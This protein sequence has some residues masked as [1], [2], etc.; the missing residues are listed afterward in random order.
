VLLPPPG[1]VAWAQGIAGGPGALILPGPIYPLLCLTFRQ[2]CGPLWGGWQ[3]SDLSSNPRS[4]HSYLSPKVWLTRGHSCTAP[5]DRGF[6]EQRPDLWSLS[7]GQVS[8]GPQERLL[9][10][11]RVLRT[12]TTHPHLNARPFLFSPTLGADSSGSLPLPS[13]EIPGAE[14]A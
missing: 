10:V 9:W 8:Q 4:V 13:I 7:Y 14:G 1:K 5:Q 3:D 12:G 11:G 2:P 6:Q